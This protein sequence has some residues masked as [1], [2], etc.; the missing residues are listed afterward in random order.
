M[1]VFIGVRCGVSG[2]DGILGSG[3]DSVKDK[4]N[5]VIYFMF[6]DLG[7]HCCDPASFVPL[8][9]IKRRKFWSSCCGSAG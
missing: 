9:P 4:S 1:Y 7:S 3:K 8:F 5:T 2:L 6:G